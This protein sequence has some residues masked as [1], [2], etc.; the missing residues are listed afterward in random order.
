MFWSFGL[1]PGLLGLRLILSRALTGSIR[2]RCRNL[3][4]LLK[5]PRE[6]RRV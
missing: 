5:L 1:A 2:E 3:V 4:D 6:S